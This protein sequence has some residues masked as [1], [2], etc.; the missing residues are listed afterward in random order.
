MQQGLLLEHLS[1]NDRAE[2]MM[3]SHQS[4]RC[5]TKDHLKKLVL[6]LKGLIEFENAVCAQGAIP[7][8]FINPDARVEC[9]DVSYPDGYMDFYFEKNFQLSDAV[10][11]EFF[12]HLSPV[13]WASL[14][15]KFGFDYPASVLAIEYNMRDGW[16]HG[17]LDPSTMTSTVFFLGGPKA[18][19]DIRSQA[20]LSYIIPFYA[21]A[22]KKAFGKTKKPIQRLTRREKEVLKWIKEGKSSWEISNI[23]KC[24]KRVVD[25]HAISIKQKLNVVSRAQAVAI[26]LQH[27]IIEF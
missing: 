21:E 13:N 17:V 5:D 24:S 22:F 14:E 19:A 25:F 9:L 4:I 16:A 20:V 10:L 11:C 3:L 23:L 2:L 26:G 18:D 1:S 6:D 15:R 27:G 8:V 12:N 7:D